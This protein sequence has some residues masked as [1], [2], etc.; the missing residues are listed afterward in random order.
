MLCCTAKKWVEVVFVD[1]F[2]QQNLLA[3]GAEVCYSQ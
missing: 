1:I 2:D 3:Y